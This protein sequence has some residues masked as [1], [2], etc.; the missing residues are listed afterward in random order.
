MPV[1]AAFW[2]L[3][4]PGRLATNLNRPPLRTRGQSRYKRLT[5]GMAAMIQSGTPTT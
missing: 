1:C 4:G 2:E 5:H 3:S